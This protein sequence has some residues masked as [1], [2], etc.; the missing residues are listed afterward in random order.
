MSLPAAHLRLL[1]R[2]GIVAAVLGLFLKQVS[3]VPRI[4]A[5][6]LACDLR[7]RKVLAYLMITRHSYKYASYHSIPTALC[8]LLALS[9]ACLL[10]IDRASIAS[11]G[12]WKRQAQTSSQLGGA[13]TNT[14]RGGRQ[15]FV[16]AGKPPAK[17]EKK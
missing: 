12:L 3:R 2:S 11:Y 8:S 10:A 7:A 6:G 16:L 4:G 9:S 13:I 17:K 15:R 5:S 14:Y 1:F